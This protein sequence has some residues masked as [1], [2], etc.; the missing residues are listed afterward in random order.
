MLLMLLTA[1]ACWADLVRLALVVVVSLLVALA[2]EAFSV[3][4][5]AGGVCL[6]LDCGWLTS[7]S[8]SLVVAWPSFCSSWRRAIYK[9][10]ASNSN[11]VTFTRSLETTYKHLTQH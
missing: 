4:G 2:M 5:G 10:H 3:G 8:T 7:S 11:T 9:T 6:G 1:G